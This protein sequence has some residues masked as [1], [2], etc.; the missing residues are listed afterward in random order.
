MGSVSIPTQDLVVILVSFLET[1][2][3]PQHFHEEVKK[4]WIKALDVVVDVVATGLPQRSPADDDASN[5]DM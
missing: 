2:L 4:S 3:G 5:S 1:A